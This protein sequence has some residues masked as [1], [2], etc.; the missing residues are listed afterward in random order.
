MPWAWALLHMIA[1]VTAQPRWQWNSASWIL[2]ETSPSNAVRIRVPRSV[3]LPR[4]C[5]PSGQ[6]DEL[7]DLGRGSRFVVP[8]IGP[9]GAHHANLTRDLTRNGQV[10][11]VRRPRPDARVVDHSNDP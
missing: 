5:G 2:R 7:V 6:P 9:V 11:P 3:G 4:R 10:R 1:A 8:T